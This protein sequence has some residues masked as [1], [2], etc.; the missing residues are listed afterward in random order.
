[1]CNLIQQFFLEYIYAEQNAQ[2]WETDLNTWNL[3][4]LQSGKEEVRRYKIHLEKC[5]LQVIGILWVITNN[6]Q[7]LE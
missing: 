7:A 2:I 3:T 6:N 5:I 4:G 1:M